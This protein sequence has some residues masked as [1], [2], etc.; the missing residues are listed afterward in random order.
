MDPVRE[1]LL[2]RALVVSAVGVL[3]IVLGW[4]GVTVTDVVSEQLVEVTLAVSLVASPLVHAWWARAHVTPV[5]DPRDAAGNLLTSVP[6]G[7]VVSFPD[8]IPAA[9]VSDD[10]GPLDLSHGG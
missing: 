10:T 2:S 3:V 1:P 5:A 9:A 8:G 4:F 7:A 6:A